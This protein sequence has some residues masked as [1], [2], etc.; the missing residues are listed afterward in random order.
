MGETVE[1]QPF[2]ADFKRFLMEQLVVP[3]ETVRCPCADAQEI[4]E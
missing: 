3:A 1:L 2:A 4:I